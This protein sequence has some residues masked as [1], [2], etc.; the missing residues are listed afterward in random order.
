MVITS[1]WPWTACDGRWRHE[2]KILLYGL[3]LCF[4]LTVAAQ[5]LPAPPE[6][7]GVFIQDGAKLLSSSTID[8]TNLLANQLW[9]D[10]AVPLYVVLLPANLTGLIE[11]QGIEKVSQD[12][13]DN[14][15][16]G[17]GD[18]NYGVLL[19]IS[20]SSKKARIEFGADWNH[21]YDA[22]AQ[23]IMDEIL[24]PAFKAGDYNQAV[25]EGT[26]ALDHLARGLGLPPR[27][28]PAW[29]MPLLV[30]GCIMIAFVVISLFR[31]G[32]SGW[33]WAFLGAVGVLV[34]FLIRNGGQGGSPRSGGTSGGGGASG[35][36]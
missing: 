15:G 27:E 25:L 35:S 22:E 3:S 19:S 9:Q 31:S 11:K 14:W 34:F 30:F 12:I 17:D 33:A 32:K 13:F 5:V 4:S 2:M 6:V 26:Q 20:P 10:E 18:R 7:S 36:W 21:R 16:L 29:V 1:R 23:E 8:A 24:I 28:K